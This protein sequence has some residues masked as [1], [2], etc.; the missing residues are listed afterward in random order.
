MG[1]LTRVSV[2]IGVTV[3]AL[4]LAGQAKARPFPEVVSL[5]AGWAAEGVATGTGTSVYAGSLATGAVWKGDLRTGAGEVLVQP[6]A[7]RVAV[8]LKQSGGL[9]FVA[10]GP[11]GQADV[12]DATTGAAVASYTLAA[13]PSFINDVTV[14]RDDAWF[15]D[16]F[17]AMLHR[18]P[19]KNGRPVGEPIEVPLTGD[20]VQVPG[21]F[22]FN[23]N[24][25]ASSPSGDALLVVN[26]TTGTLYRVD[27][28]DGVATAV[29]TS[30]VLTS[31]DGIL[32]RGREL[33]V[34]RNQSNEIAILRMSPDLGSATL[35]KT[36]TD[37]DFA[38]PTTVAAFGSTLYAV[39]ARFG[40]TSPDPLP[41]E[42]VKVDGS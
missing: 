28:V 20:W 7:G 31:G 13:S 1:T 39:N 33:A 32:L 22:V 26:S 4:A 29:Q 34:V 5:P 37:P 16:S 30:A 25:I 3:A 10:G 42:I 14:T 38:V 6:Q 36:L 15:T 27:P 40:Q 2:T 24:G 18:I 17:N 41:Y 12:Y 11:T 23:A 8:G 19:L 21:S 9:L 35:V